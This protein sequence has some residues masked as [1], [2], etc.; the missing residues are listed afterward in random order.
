MNDSGTSVDRL[1]TRYDFGS[2]YLTYIPLNDM[3]HLLNEPKKFEALAAK[4]PFQATLE[5]FRGFLNDNRERQLNEAL[6]FLQLELSTG[7]AGW[8]KIS[9]RDGT[10]RRT[11][12]SPS[13]VWG[14]A[15]FSDA[16]LG[17]HLVL[18]EKD[19]SIASGT[20]SVAQA[21]EDI[22]SLK[23]D[24]YI[25]TLRTVALDR[26]FR[27][28]IEK[29]SA[30]LDVLKAKNQPLY[31]A[32]HEFSTGYDRSVAA[33]NR[34]KALEPLRLKGAEL[35]D[36]M[37]KFTTRYEGCLAMLRTKK[38]RDSLKSSAGRVLKD[39]GYLNVG[40]ETGD[41][42]FI[43]MYR[44]L[45]GGD[46]VPRIVTTQPLRQLLIGPGKGFLDLGRGP[47]RHR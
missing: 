18:E 42:T 19:A 32:V 29:K 15:E 31:A 4:P 30:E 10:I 26:D 17:S 6:A 36:A 35:S 27:S 9:D 47:P 20:I 5:R 24:P 7:K 13:E 25:P 11:N 28:M 33:L 43:E 16:F 21:W 8:K 34:Q 3:T 14:I 41:E 38:V 2:L 12:W 45:T 40:E 46:A 37:E 23:K 22:K 1:K 44:N 39:L